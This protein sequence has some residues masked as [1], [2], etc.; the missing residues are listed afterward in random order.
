VSGRRDREN[1]Q[2]CAERGESYANRASPAMIAEW[3]FTRLLKNIGFVGGLFLLST[4]VVGKR[5]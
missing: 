4:A 1:N 5:R 3:V 2:P